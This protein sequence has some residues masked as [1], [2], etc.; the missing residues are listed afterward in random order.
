MTGDGESGFGPLVEAQWLAANADSVV[1]ADVRWYLDGRSGRDAYSSGHITGA[2]FVDLDS[3]LSAPPD[4][5]GGR[6]PLPSPQDFAKAMSRLGIGD[7]CRV[8]AYDDSGGIT[9]ARLWWMLDCLGVAAAVLDGGL[10]SWRAAHPG[11]LQNDSP[12]WQP[13]KFTPRQWPQERFAGIAEVDSASRDD[14]FVVIDARAHERYRGE[15]NAV[16][17]RF[18]HIPGAVSMPATANLRGSKLL[19]ADELRHR[20]NEVG[21]ADRRVI[22]YCG[23]GVSA[24]HDLLALRHA[25]LADGRLFVGSWSAWG[26]DPDRPVATA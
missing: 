24:C 7:D 16:D 13:R 25:G 3:D 2:R 8:V 21:A 10:D 17:P 12:Q 15:P 18:G 5:S 9:A 19:P 20:Y 22:A 14:S 11:S 1:I 23:S 6:H 26:A 4:T